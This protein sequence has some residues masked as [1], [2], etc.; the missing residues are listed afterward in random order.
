MA[1][2][3]HAPDAILAAWSSLKGC[4]SSPIAVGNINQT[5]RVEGRD[6]PIVLQRVHPV[7]G[8]EVHEDIDAITR[9]LEAKGL[10]TP[11]LVPTDT[12]ALYVLDD[13]GAPW[14]AQT[15]VNGVNIEKIQSP[16]RAWAAG[17]LAARFHVAL[18]DLEHTYRHVRG[19][20]HDTRAHLDRLKDAVATL[21]DHRLHA[22][23]AELAEQ[24]LAAA[25]PLPDFS[26]LVPRH[27]HGDLK[28]SNL[29][30]ANEGGEAAEGLCCIDL[31]TL[32]LMIWPYEFGDALRSWCNPR[33]EDERPVC[34]EPDL[35]KAAVGGYASIAGHRV[36]DDERA[37]LLPGV[38]TICLELSARFL[39]DALREAYFGYDPSR[40]PAPGE[41]HLN[42]GRAMRELAA[43]VDE[44]RGALDDALDK[45]FS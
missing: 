41:H 38:R 3:G 12:S 27:S 42:R 31:D 24:V 30:F 13:E 25:E 16:E 9:H 15:F 19:N 21:S 23:V 4:R 29:L 40:Y 7:F 45:A 34:F 26:S 6:G 17:V 33:A 11:R 2:T 22:E 32:S 44:Q 18:D 37:L 43:S 5:Y 10:L 20:V 39:D 28:I 8:P 1:A 36:T 14:R 35:F